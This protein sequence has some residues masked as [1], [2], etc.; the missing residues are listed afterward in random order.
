VVIRDCEEAETQEEGK[1]NRAGMVLTKKDFCPPK[2][3]V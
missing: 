1:E 3:L 2:A